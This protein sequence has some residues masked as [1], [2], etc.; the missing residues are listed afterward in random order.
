[1]KIKCACSVERARGAAGGTTRHHHVYFRRRFTFPFR[2]RGE[3]GNRVTVSAVIENGL[4][5]PFLG[6]FSLRHKP[7][8]ANLLGFR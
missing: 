3:R 7:A 2:R 6:S 1:M 8:S 4:A 5:K